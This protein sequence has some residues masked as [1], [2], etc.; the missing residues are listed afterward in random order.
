MLLTEATQPPY[1]QDS[2]LTSKFAKLIKAIGLV[3][4]GAYKTMVNPALF[5]ADFWVK[6]KE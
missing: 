5:P 2:L 3:D 1:I 4:T 6:S